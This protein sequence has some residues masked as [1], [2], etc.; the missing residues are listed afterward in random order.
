MESPDYQ[1]QADELFELADEFFQKFVLQGNVTDLDQYLHFT[2]EQINIAPEGHPDRA[3]HTFTLGDGYS[4]KYKKTRNPEDLERSIELKEESINLGRKDSNP[5]E[6]SDGDKLS[7]IADYQAKF[8]LTGDRVILEQATRSCEEEINLL[9]EKDPI[10]AAYLYRAGIGY[11]T[12]YQE[13]GE[14]VSLE[15]SI[16]YYREALTLTPKNDPQRPLRLEGL[17]NGLRDWFQRIGSA[18]ALE[19]AI[20]LSEEALDLTSDD[21]EDRAN[22]LFYLA[23]LYADRQVQTGEKDH[24]HS[25]ALIKEA[26]HVAPV[27]HPARAKVLAALSTA[28][29][30]EHSA[31]KVENTLHE[32]IQRGNEALLEIKDSRDRSRPLDVLG[33]AYRHLYER[34]D[35]VTDL[36]LSIQHHKSAV[37]E[38]SEQ[39]PTRAYLLRGLAEGY[40]AKYHSTKAA[41]DWELSVRTFTEALAHSLSSADHRLQAGRSL[42]HFHAGAGRWEEAYGFALK[43]IRL[44]PLL[45]GPALEN[46]DKQVLLAEISGLA[47]DAAA[48]AL[49][50]EKTTL[51]A[52]QLLGLGRGVISASVHASPSREASQGGEERNP[53]VQENSSSEGFPEVLS[54]NELK[55]AAKNGP[56]LIIST[57]SY[58]CDAFIIEHNDIHVLPLPKL[59]RND[60]NSYQLEDLAQPKI[61]EW[62]WTTLAKPVLDELGLGQIGAN[63]RWPHVWWIPTGV[64]AKYPI[65][66][67]SSYSP[68]SSGSVL[69]RVV[70]SYSTSVKTIIQGHSR[71][72]QKVGTSRPNN[73]VLVGMEETPG[74]RHLKYAVE[75]VEM[76]ERAFKS[77]NLHTTKPLPVQRDVLSAL[78]NCDIFHFAGHGLSSHRSPWKS[79]LLLRDWEKQPLTVEHLYEVNAGKRTAFLA[80]LSACGTG[81][82][83]HGEFLDEGLHLATACQLAGFQHV[84]GTLWEV[85]DKA[86]VDIAAKT[87]EWI[88]REGMSDESVSEGLHHALRS[89]RAQW[90]TENVSRGALKYQEKIGCTDGSH[91][92]EEKRHNSKCQRDVFFADE[93]MLSSPPWVP[94]I[95]FGI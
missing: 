22:R 53:N 47:S 24:Y 12:V 18:A 33:Y 74:Q 94:Y 41:A 58:R 38:A 39:D 32:C 30:Q 50:S 63:E 57:S 4:R 23:I 2:Q 16:R 75:E 73:V 91:I 80:Y 61:L 13:S 81:Q 31:K 10:R 17:G 42:L 25:I 48:V 21:H 89:L 37:D 60:I 88:Q 9:P 45:T 85:N 36:E 82:I 70:S 7:L 68:T 77:L 3:Q 49:N 78:K 56:I 69:D 67:A 43:S 92:A 83:L 8:E 11:G 86:C 66:A 84:I 62:L 59:K 28:Y 93:S 1:D 34:T 76:L 87:Y 71:Q 46:S 55:A 27:G 65:H 6:L 29:L 95:H 19:E 20:Q 35:D 52:I 72:A 40:E 44:I 54:E 26:I 51:E 15:Q 90:I 79:S 64:L 5:V 14:K